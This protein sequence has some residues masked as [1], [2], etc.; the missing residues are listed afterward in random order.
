M[1]SGAKSSDTRR[2]SAQASRPSST[3]VPV[4]IGVTDAD[5]PTS[6]VARYNVSQLSLLVFLF[7]HRF[8]DLLMSCGHRH[9]VDVYVS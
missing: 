6:Q 2:I 7:C 8:L 5:A 1:I 3:E 4:V 9:L